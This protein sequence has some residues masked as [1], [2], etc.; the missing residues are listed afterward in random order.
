MGSTSWHQDHL[1]LTPDRRGPDQAVA[2]AAFTRRHLME[3][4]ALGV[5]GSHGG[6]A[7]STARGQLTWATHVSLAPTW[8]DPAETGGIVTPFMLLYAI[9]DGLMKPM[10]GNPSDLCLA[11]THA[12]SADGLT[13]EFVLRDGATFHNGE[14][15]TAAD[16]KFSFERYR[17]SAVRFIKD[18]VA[19]VETPDPGRVIFRLHKPWPDFLTYYGSVT[20]A[21]WIVPKAYLERVGDD[22]FKKAPIG[23]GP[24]KFVSFNPGVELVLEAFD[25]YWRKPPTV[26]RLV[27]KVVPDET[28]RLAALKRGEVDIA[29][30]IR[31]EM[32]EELKRT[33]G[34]QLK[35]AVLNGT[36]W[37][38]FPD[39]WDPK[40]PWYD[41]RVRKAA[42][43]A[44][45]YDSINTAIT[46]GHSLIT[47]S[48]VPKAFDFY[49]APPKPSY[50]PKMARALLAEAGYP[51]G[52]E[53]GDHFC[54]SSYSN[55]AEAVLNNL[56]E[57]GI[58][59]KLRPIERAAFAQG[60]AEKKFRN[61]IQG[62]SGA[63][64]NAATRL[65]T[66]VIKGGSYVYGSYPDIDELF[67][68][69]ADE[70]DR[71]RR[72]AILHH[73]QQ[74]A[75][76]RAIYA[77]IW[78]LGFLNGQGPRVEESGFGLIA[79]YPYSSPYEDLRLKTG[80]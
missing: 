36:Q 72:E 56:L 62:G 14:K 53:A 51:D 69:Q 31:G 38:Y 46:L 4:A 79:G 19:S 32:A 1:A 27:L 10:P 64:G 11:E 63:F 33:P 8:F 20:G 71:A 40:S 54:D 74:L 58:R 17:G 66:F 13:H 6:A 30:S 42:A 80:A 39:Q 73:M 3:L 48:I 35:A 23:A 21:G 18:K 50:D 37:L 55:V 49:W 44:M 57:V 70:V 43:L 76:E 59:A 78:Q 26:K 7:A 16:V 28:T 67:A 9:H 15:V 77:P 52:F 45:D 2:P 47:G 65:E 5:L 60:Y 12:A 29:Y 61:I 34:L 68:R 22:G 25:D 24:Y 41:V 75:H